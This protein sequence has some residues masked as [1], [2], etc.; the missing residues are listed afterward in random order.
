MGCGES[1]GY[2]SFL[3]HKTPFIVNSSP[4][5]LPS[6][7]P[8][9]TLLL[10][11]FTTPSIFQTPP[12]LP[13]TNPIKTQTPVLNYSNPSYNYIPTP[14]FSQD[15]ED[16][17]EMKNPDWMSVMTYI[18]LIYNHFNGIR[19]GGPRLPPGPTEG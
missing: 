3:S 12:F 16:M 18:S 17:V 15:V 6:F 13:L 1:R 10:P 4:P 11:S 5:P 14:H 19:V 2:S 9:L 8:P 7:D